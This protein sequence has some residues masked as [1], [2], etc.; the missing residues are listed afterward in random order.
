MPI[1]LPNLD[2]RTYAQ[3]VE[4]ARSLIPGLCPDWTN[5]NPSDPGMMLI[6]LFAWLTE[7]LLYRVDQIPDAHYRA[8][9]QLLI[10][11]K[12]WKEKEYEGLSIEEAT[13]RIML[14]L[15]EPYRLVTERDYEDLA[16][17]RAEPGLTRLIARAHC[18]GNCNLG[19]NPPWNL[20]G[21]AP[22]YMSLIVVPGLVRTRKPF[23]LG[24]GQKTGVPVTVSDWE[25]LPSPAPGPDPYAPGELRV[26]LSGAPG[27][28]A[29]TLTIEGEG[30]ELLSR[31]AGPGQDEEE[32]RFR[33]A[34]QV[35]AATVDPAIAPLRLTI[36]GP[37]EQPAGSADNIQGELGL[38][39][40]PQS[41]RLTELRDLCAARRLLTTR[42]IVV[43]PTYVPFRVS[44][45]LRMKDDALAETVRREAVARLRRYFHPLCGGRDG[46]GWP[47][48]RAVY[49]SEVYDILDRVP[50][51]DAAENVVLGSEDFRRWDA[52]N[53]RLYAHE[54]VDLQLARNDLKLTL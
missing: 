11:A 35:G 43:G 39:Y 32:W 51:V 19:A 5:H 16:L 34:D 44:A 10:G 17:N 50:G 21:Q 30:C 38:T 27:G 20:P 18:I 23:T 29:P 9:L 46:K 3:L 45:M 48:G 52:E 12:E 2:N 7:L 22:G 14:M 49:L 4:E 37:Q 40:F 47:F 25:A 13:R 53:I 8:F 54:L 42:S 31:T 1:P 26:R 36:N 28:L 33:V 41:L 6:E 24:Q 15:R